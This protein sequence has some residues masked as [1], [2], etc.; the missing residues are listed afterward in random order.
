LLFIFFC[1]YCILFL[2]LFIFIFLMC[3]IYLCVVMPVEILNLRVDDMLY[4]SG[5]EFSS[6]FA[7]GG[8]VCIFFPSHTLL[9]I[10][11]GAQYPGLWSLEIKELCS[12]TGHPGV[13]KLPLESVPFIIISINTV[14]TYWYGC[15][16]KDA[17][18]LVTFN[19]K[20]G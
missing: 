7:G 5:W 11:S 9:H 17:I 13:Q 20:L 3:Y 8:W 15:M 1:I 6:C 19:R 4:I 12:K 14:I 2:E 18:T 16:V 10:M